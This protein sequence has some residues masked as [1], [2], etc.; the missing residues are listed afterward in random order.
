MYPAILSMCS[1]TKYSIPFTIAVAAARRKVVVRDFTPEGIHA[2]AALQLAQ[3]VTARLDPRFN[4]KAHT[5]PPGMVEIKTRDGKVYSQRC[6]FPYGH[7]G[8]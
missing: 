2:P 6:D 5:L 4:M 1:F 3:R 7:P 8:R